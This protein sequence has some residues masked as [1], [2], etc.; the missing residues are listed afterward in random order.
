MSSWRWKITTNSARHS[1]AWFPLTPRLLCGEVADKWQLESVSVKC[2][3][4]AHTPDQ[5]PSQ[6]N[7]SPDHPVNE[8]W[9]EEHPNAEN[10][11][12]NNVDAECHNVQED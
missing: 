1:K 2:V 6:L 11:S 10:D 9:E 8:E 4:Y 7:Q 3:V 12:Q 5:Q